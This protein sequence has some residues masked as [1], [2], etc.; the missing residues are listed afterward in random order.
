MEEEIRELL[1]KQKYRQVENEKEEVFQI[2]YKEQGEFILMLALIKKPAQK[3]E[4]S[5]EVEFFHGLKKMMQ[6]QTTKTVIV[7]HWIIL[8][9]E[10]GE[11][12]RR[13]ALE[14]DNICFI[15]EKNKKEYIFD[16][17]DIN[18][19]SLYK[20]LDA[21]LTGNFKALK[22]MQK[23]ERKKRY[24]KEWKSI[25][26]RMTLANTI[27]VL[28][29]IFVFAFVELSGNPSILESGAMEWRKVCFDGQYYRLFTCMFL[30]FGAAHLFSNVVFLFL[31]GAYL[32]RVVGTIKYLII[33]F[34]AGI[35]SSIV[36]LLYYYYQDAY[37]LSAGASGAL[38]GIIGA[39]LYVL[40]RN[41]GKVEEI[42]WKDFL[43]M[44]FGTILAGFFTENV[45]NA[46]HVGGVFVGFLLAVLCYH[47]RKRSKEK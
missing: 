21:L 27:L 9:D 33:Y 28:I 32:E 5:F 4:L 11:E 2:Y 41:R 29:N 14:V 12:D 16:E 13:L 10:P 20:Q 45:D 26:E 7:S 42:H 23:E 46:A 24:K 40:I 31:M 30:H 22:R 36:S 37:V 39:L 3:R 15:D 19:L 34:G 38:F 8:P 6:E 25:Y 47:P 44:M 35:G 18:F 17:V 1:R 43:I